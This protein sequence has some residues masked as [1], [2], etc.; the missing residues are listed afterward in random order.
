MIDYANRRA[1]QRRAIV[2]PAVVGLDDDD[3]EAVV[4]C[5]TID[6]SSGGVK[7]RFPQGT[8]VP[9]VFRVSVPDARVKNRR[10]RMVWRNGTE[11]G[12][13]YL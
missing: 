2:V 9:P 1:F 3:K 5:S 7:L 8:V 10:A 11:L 6:I 4:R 13:V 12:V